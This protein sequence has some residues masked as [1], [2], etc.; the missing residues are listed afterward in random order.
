MFPG[1]ECSFLSFFSS[2][3]TVRFNMFDSFFLSLGQHNQADLERKKQYEHLRPQ[4]KIQRCRTSKL[5]RITE[6]CWGRT[7]HVQLCLPFANLTEIQTSRCTT[8][9]HNRCNST[10]CRESFEKFSWKGIQRQQS[11]HLYNI[12]V[13]TINIAYDRQAK[14]EKVERRTEQSH[15]TSRQ[16]ASSPFPRLSRRTIVGCPLFLLGAMQSSLHL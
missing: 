9:C 11:S 3:I 6:R 13:L 15:I 12:S 1:L 16:T 8:I 10:A 7:V 5:T 4:K 2:I 14:K